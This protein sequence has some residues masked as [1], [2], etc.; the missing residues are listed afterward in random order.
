MGKP[1]PPPP[2][3]P[4]LELSTSDISPRRNESTSPEP[5]AQDSAI[6]LST[7]DLSTLESPAPKSLAH[8]S[9][10]ELS[11]SDTSPR[12]NESTSPE[13]L[14]QD[15]AIELSASDLSTLESPAPKSLAH[16]S[17]I[18]LSASDLSPLR[19]ESTSPEPLAHDSAI[20]LSA[21]DISTLRKGPPPP[22]IPALEEQDV[23]IPRPRVSTGANEHRHGRGGDTVLFAASEFGMALAEL[24]QRNPQFLGAVLCDIEGDPIDFARRPTKISSLDIQIVGA[25]LQLSLNKLT[26]PAKRHGFGNW[27]AVIEASHG[28]VVGQVLCGEFVFALL[29][30][31]D[32]DIDLLLRLCESSGRELTELL[33]A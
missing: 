28:T 1:P 22:P 19:N 2:E 30:V 18:E 3:P 29:C 16:D 7:S 5:L 23:P 9:A 26:G 8:D 27:I 14:A 11:A 4:A 32:M 10:I 6:E 21:S 31:P 13:P 12:R 33:E 15:S 17:A 24:L 25:Q 20:E